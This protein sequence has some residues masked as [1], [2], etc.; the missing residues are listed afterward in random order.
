MENQYVLHI[1]T[2]ALVV[3]FAMCMSYI[4][5]SCMAGVALQ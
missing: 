5:L 2:V 1:L 3:Q 4:I